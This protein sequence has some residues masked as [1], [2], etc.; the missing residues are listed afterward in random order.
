[1][2]RGEAKVKVIAGALQPKGLDL[3]QFQ[4][5]HG[6]RPQKMNAADADGVLTFAGSDFPE[7][8][9][10][11]MTYG[12][13]LPGYLLR[14]KYADQHSKE[15]FVKA[16]EILIRRHGLATKRSEM[17][18]CIATTAVFEWVH[19]ACPECRKSSKKRPALTPCPLCAPTKVKTASGEEIVGRISSVETKNGE[20]RVVTSGA[21]PG[22][23]RCHGMGSI[24]PAITRAKGIRCLSCRGSGRV[25][26]KRKRRWSLVND[27]MLGFQDQR[28]QLPD[29]IGL[30]V[31][32]SHWHPKYEAF[33]TTL[34]L[35]DSHMGL[36]LDLGF[37]ARAS[38]LDEPPHCGENHGE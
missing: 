34:R 21:R 14:L 9:D 32:L 26:F 1:M 25:G 27:L 36:G 12:D 6:R 30:E 23:P 2:S 19:D 15:L 20:R 31:F 24:L 17:M 5:H 18:R 4:K 8:P 22:C 13:P 35:A 11:E 16:V 28:G 33:L 38:R 37:R 29:G 10:G 7:S 3:T